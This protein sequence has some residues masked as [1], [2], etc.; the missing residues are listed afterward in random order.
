MR[1]FYE[2]FCG[3][4]MVRMALSDG[5]RCLI[6]NDH[7]PKKA[8]AYRMNFGG[9]ALRVCDVASLTAA[10]LPGVAD[11]CWA[12]PPCQDISLA[13]RG[14]G[15][16]LEEDYVNLHRRSLKPTRSGSFWP[17]IRLMRSL[18]SEGRA[19]RMIV[20]EN[21]EGLAN[22]RKGADY[23][24]VQE[25]LRELGYYLFY[26]D[27]VIDASAFLPQSRRRVFVVG[28]RTPWGRHRYP[29]LPTPTP[30]ADRP[31]LASLID[32]DA[33]CDPLAKTA[34]LLEAMSETNRLKLAEAQ[35][36]GGLQV[37]CAY[38]RTRRDGPQWEV[39]FDG[40]AGC[41]RTAA[42]GSSRQTLLFVNGAD[43]RS[44][45]M[46]P[47]ECAR[48]TGL[49]EHYRLPE[50]DKDAY[51]LVGDGVAPPVVAWLARNVLEP[52]LDAM[53]S[54]RAAE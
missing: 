46:S 10:D 39:R 52:A 34:K 15:L 28:S 50:T 23:Y 26:G 21:V 51:D 7:D 54:T 36:R 38:R 33:P 32:L 12:S 11:L 1:T 16:G 19:P 35:A 3:G 41:L 42:G 31:S 13:G 43:V 27:S 29:T 53:A 9:E 2:M 22:G 5:W 48:L 8:A 47:R 24:W 18:D 14:A 49:P 20:V 6:A 4:G 17:W 25:A 30:I 37:G 45:I 44:R 40:T